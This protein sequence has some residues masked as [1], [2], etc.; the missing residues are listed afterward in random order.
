MRVSDYIADFLSSKGIEQV[1]LITGRGSLF[2]TDGIA[3]NKDL[4]PICLHHE[5]AAAFAAIANSEISEKPSACMVSTGCAS[6][7]VLTAVLSAWQDGIP[8][9]FISGQN[10]LNE[11]TRYTKSDIR[12]FGQQEADIVEIVRSITKYSKMIEDPKSIKFEMEKAYDI[13]VQGKK[14]PVWIDVPLDIQSTNIDVKNLSSYKKVSKNPLNEVKKNKKNAGIIKNL[15][16]KSSRPVL[17]VGAGV[18]SSN[19]ITELKKLSEDNNIPV[20]FTSSGADIYGSKNKLSIGSVGS[21]GCSRSGNFTVQ[22]S[23]LL[24]VIGS[25]MTS[26]NTGIDYCKFARNSKVILIDQDLKEHDKEGIKYTK[27]IETNIKDLLQEINKLKIRK[28][29]QNWVKTCLRWKRKFK[30]LNNFSLS[31]QIDLY[32][33]ADTFSKTL[34]AKSCFV[35]DSGFIDVIMP[36][37]INFKNGQR[38]VHPVSQGAMGFALPAAIGCSHAFRGPI[39][40]VIGDGSIMMNL[41]ELQTVAHHNIPLKIFVINNNAYAIINRRQ[42]ELFR[43]R[44]IGTNPSDGLSIPDFKKVADA[45]NIKYQ[46]IRT[47]NNL[48]SKVKKVLQ[49]N[50]PILCEVF[51]REDQSYIEISHARDSN[52][53]FVRRPLE[54]QAPF[55]DRKIFLEEMIIKPIDQ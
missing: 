53:K 43:K 39:I 24:I 13:S 2:L 28:T 22:N 19:A 50:G 52:K 55:M 36:T 35:C 42:K 29:N 31:K 49:K 51:A 17:L 44:T 15:I 7:N 21:Q 8:C 27:K 48:E 4:E 20:T 5:Q 37:N 41:Q 38:C 14:G 10:V 1:Y 25:R 32:E 40:A 18:R 12:T 46:S 3:R 34:P 47:K 45:F 6:T 30:K 54:D 9:I 16:N 11:T 23:D 33:L 26:L